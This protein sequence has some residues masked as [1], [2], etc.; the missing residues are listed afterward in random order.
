MR[1]REE[2]ERER[3]REGERKEREKSGEEGTSVCVSAHQTAR[4]T[5]LTDLLYSCS[6]AFQ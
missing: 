4:E 3:G 5:V 6:Q 1:E 2:R